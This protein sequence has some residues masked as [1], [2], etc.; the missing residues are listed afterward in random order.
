MQTRLALA[1][2]CAVRVLLLMI[3]VTKLTEA[4]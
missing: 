3:I 2:V 1:E 4:L